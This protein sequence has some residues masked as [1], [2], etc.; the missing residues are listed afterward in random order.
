MTPQFSILVSEAMDSIGY[1]EQMIG[2]RAHIFKKWFDVVSL[3]TTR[4]YQ[5][6]LILAGSKSEGVVP[7]FGSDFDYMMVSQLWICVDYGRL[8]DKMIIIETDL[9]EC[10][11]GYTKLRRFIPGLCMDYIPSAAI[12]EFIKN[13]D[14]LCLHDGYKQ[15]F[16]TI[17]G[18]AMNSI[19][20]S[21][22][23]F[24]VKISDVSTD[25]VFAIR[26]YT[27][28]FLRDWA[29][30][31]RQFEWPPPNVIEDVSTTE[32]YIVPVGNKLS[33]GQSLEWRIC[34]TTGECK[35]VA[36]FNATQLKLYVLLKMTVK[37]ILK[38]AIDCVSFYMVKNVVFWVMEHTPTFVFTPSNLTKCVIHALWFLL[39]CLHNDYL[40]NY[41]IPNRN[42]LLG[43]VHGNQIAEKRHLA[44]ELLNEGETIVLKCEK[45]R[46]AMFVAECNRSLATR[47]QSWR[48]EIEQ[49]YL[50]FNLNSIQIRTS[51]M[52]LKRSYIADTFFE[53]LRDGS[54]LPIICRLL[55]LL[56]F[57]VTND[58]NV[59]N[60][61]DLLHN[62]L[63]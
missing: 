23:L 12:S 48:D 27:S 21:N 47:I 11:P 22:I 25:H 1:S 46:N 28:T 50:L 16:K 19:W 40:P 15:I 20:Q 6:E 14:L 63:S 53:H 26:Y 18:P 9:N 55:Y 31:S 58:A 2:F 35:L 56:F 32:G 10:P 37:D 62:L 42:L 57:D 54:Y 24:G 43:R 17:S 4:N 34:F 59:Q 45:L 29:K 38:P 7:F 44:R 3:H 61:L 13:S 60:V 49:L 33:E 51:D 36:S 39:H 5:M 41:M 8:E 30:R 52:M